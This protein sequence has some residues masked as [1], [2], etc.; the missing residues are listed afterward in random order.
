MQVTETQ[1]EGLKRAYKVVISATELDDKIAHRLEELSGQIRI[2]GF[3]PG[4]A[5]LK[6]LRQRFGPSV[7][8]EVLEKAVTDSSSQ[9]LSERNLRPASQPKIEIVSADDGKDLEYSMEL[10]ILPEIVPM[11]FSALELERVKITVGDQEVEEALERIAASNKTTREPAKAKQAETGDSIVLDFKGTV[12]GVAHP[13]MEATDHQLELGSSSFIAGFEEQLV[14][15]KAG[16]ARTVSVTFPDEYVNDEL[17]GKE[18]VF[19]C[20][21]KQVLETVPAEV[22]DELAEKLGAENLAGL[23]QKVRE[24]LESEYAR[25]SRDKMKR[26][27][28]DKL[29]DAHDFPAP[30]GMVDA[31]FDVIWQQIT[32]DKERGVVD[33]DD[34]DKDEEALR[35][36]YRGIAERRVRLGLLLSE[37]GR[38]NAIDVTQEEVNAAIMREAMQWPGQEQQVFK[39]YQENAQALAQLRAP[40]FEEKVV[41]YIAELA[42]VDERTLTLD[43]LK[44]EDGITDG[45]ETPAKGAKKTKAKKASTAKSK[46]AKGKTETAKPKSDKTKSEKTKSDKPKAAK[47]KKAKAADKDDE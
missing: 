20:Q 30:L 32:A 5:P 47:A 11:E 41:D 18:A 22:N 40:L 25:L 23:T 1:T 46:T 34:A 6:V 43:E 4:K 33:P 39:F 17:A 7:R 13:G 19:E 45:D 37:V 42:K 8:G 38:I 14:G 16:E 10:E 29:A 44:A 26:G 12:G 2:P 21:I 24:Q 27:M 9:A 31:E 15:A 36:E 3:R 28:L 35:E